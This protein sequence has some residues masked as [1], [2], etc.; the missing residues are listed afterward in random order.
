[1]RKLRYRQ[2]PVNRS[3]KRTVNPDPNRYR[4]EHGKYVIKHMDEMIE[5]LLTTDFFCDV[6]AAPTAC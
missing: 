3:V 5:S 4:D 6:R 2:P 1:M